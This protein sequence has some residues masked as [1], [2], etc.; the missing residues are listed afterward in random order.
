MGGLAF[1]A[2]INVTSTTVETPAEAMSSAT[3]VLLASTP[4]D[5]ALSQAEGSTIWS[6]RAGEVGEQIDDLVREGRVADALALVNAIGE[7]GLAPVSGRPELHAKL[8]M[9]AQ[10]RRLAHLRPLH[11]VQHF[12][13]GQYQTAMDTFLSDNINPALVISLFPAE[14]MSRKLHVSRDQWMSL[15][16]AVEFARLEPEVVTSTESGGISTRGLLRSMAHLGV[17]ATKKP[18]LDTLRMAKEE[19]DASVSSAQKLALPTSKEECGSSLRST[20]NHSRYECSTSSRTRS[21]LVFLL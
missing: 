4:T 20:D 8:N 21:T 2:L 18:S 14:S 17:G 7:A 3:K 9:K 13:R 1:G 5:K 10:T 16:G 11:A 15:F 6:L 12:A 19:D